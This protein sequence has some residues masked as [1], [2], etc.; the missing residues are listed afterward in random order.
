MARLDQAVAVMRASGRVE[1]KEG[2]S[3]HDADLVGSEL[4]ERR[5][6]G[7]GREQV[8]RAAVWNAYRGGKV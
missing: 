1:V 2:R 7:S 6:N 8:Q 3:E 5:D 4:L